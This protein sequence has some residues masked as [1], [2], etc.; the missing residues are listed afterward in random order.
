MPDAVGAKR[1]SGDAAVA[2]DVSDMDPPHVVEGVGCNA[3]VTAASGP[4]STWIRNQTPRWGLDAIHR[5]RR[6]RKCSSNANGRM[7]RV[8]ME[9][10]GDE[11]GLFIPA[12]SFLGALEVVVNR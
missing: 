8:D 3:G 9:R 7:A 6:S 12:A 10:P 1:S 2:A 4:R 5:A 11:P